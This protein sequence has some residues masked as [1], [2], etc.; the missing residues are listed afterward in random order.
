LNF[1]EDWVEPLASSFPAV[2]GWAREKSLS[3][4]SWCANLGEVRNPDDFFS[5]PAV[6]GWERTPIVKSPWKGPGWPDSAG[7]ARIDPTQA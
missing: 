5:S 1:L 2:N 4:A 7:T 3:L 6:H